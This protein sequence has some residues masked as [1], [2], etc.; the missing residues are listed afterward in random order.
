MKKE[1]LYHIQGVAYSYLVLLSS[2]AV[3]LFFSFEGIEVGSD[4]TYRLKLSPQ[5]VPQPVLV[6][7]FGGGVAGVVMRAFARVTGKV[8][9][10]SEALQKAGSRILGEYAKK[11]AEDQEEDRIEE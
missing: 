5:K 9:P 1:T 4:L 10:D 8:L 11:L 3:V 6:Y 2:V 7:A